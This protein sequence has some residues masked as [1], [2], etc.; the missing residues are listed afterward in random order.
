VAQRIQ[1]SIKA[2]AESVGGSSRIVNST[3]GELNM[4]RVT[5]EHVYNERANS[6]NFIP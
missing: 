1:Q 5:H 2:G 4:P 6:S 3:I